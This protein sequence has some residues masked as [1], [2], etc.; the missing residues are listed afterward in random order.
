MKNP[1]AKYLAAF[2][3]TLLLLYGCSNQS[4]RTPKQQSIPTRQ[5][6]PTASKEKYPRLPYSE[7]SFSFAVL[8]D[9]RPAA[10]LLPQPNNF[11]KLIDQINEEKPAFVIHTGDVVAGGTRKSALYIRQYKDFLSTIAK[12]RVSYHLAPGNH[13]IENRSGQKAF[14]QILNRELYYSFDHNDS[15]FIILNTDTPGEAGRIGAD[16]LNWLKEDLER[17]KD[18]RH[19]F[20]AMHRPLYSL[21]NPE[22]KRNGHQSFTDRR[23][24][25]E[26][27][28]LMT[29]YQVDAV[30]AG[31]EHFFNKQVRDGVTYI[32]TGVA[33]ASPYANEKQGGFYHYV[34]VKVEGDSV[35]MEVVKLGGEILRPDSVAK[36]VFD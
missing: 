32:I 27:R 11:L 14:K 30:F 17:N 7:R 31:H 22:R 12:L 3:V 24:E 21:M 23:S 16:Q 26:V 35:H 36:P 6:V 5:D 10:P 8:G 1:F 13:D 19:I 33:G 2:A 15:H 9:S 18:D 28:R 29:E 20:V 34:R 4:D 25:Y